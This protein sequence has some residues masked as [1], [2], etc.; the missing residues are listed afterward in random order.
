MVRWNRWEDH[1]TRRARDEKW[2]ARSVYKLEEIDRRFK[3]IRQGNHL[4]DLGCYPGSWSQYSIKRVGPR[5]EVVGVDLKGPDNPLS[6]NF[7]FIRADVFTLDPGW[8]ARE[9]GPRDT[10]ISDLAP[11]T[12]GI[13]GVDTSRSMELA[14]K[15]LSIAFMMLKKRG[16]FLCKVFEGEDLKAYKDEIS[17]CFDQV[18]IIRP[19]AVRRGSREVFLLGLELVK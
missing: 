19:R 4:L 3:L 16:H 1:Y 13:R 17:S 7:R 11:Q 6:P 9:I 12:T 15:A 10:V 14:G 8:L 2:P 18:R 5:G